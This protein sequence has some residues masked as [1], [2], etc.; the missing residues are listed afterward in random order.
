M[1]PTGSAAVSGRR[2]VNSDD[3]LRLMA[4]VARL[5]HERGMTQA[6]IASE[7][8]ISQARVSRL[9]KNATEVGIVRT[10]VTL[11]PGVHTDIEES[12][13]EK[14][15]PQGLADA[16]V[17]D[18]HGLDS[19]RALG[20]A[21]A[22]FLE[23]TLLGGDRVGISSWSATLLAM[24]EAMRP[25]RVP[26]ADRVVQLLGGMGDQRVQMQASRLLGLFASCTG[27]EPVFMPAP[28]MLG[29]PEARDSL[30]AD[31][32][33][34]TVM[35]MWPQ[36]SLALVGIG[37]LE[38]SPLLR[39]SGNALAAT[40]LKQL[41]KAGAVGDVCLRFFDAKG[42]PVDSPVNDRIV[43]I[44]HDELL[45]IPRRVG[46]AGGPNKHAAIRGALLGGWV[47]VLITD[48]EEAERLLA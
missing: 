48:L 21:A 39:E 27:A 33:V 14:Y 10:T 25:S 38:A 9:L 15:G 32:T 28:G 4:K 20:S 8:H 44:A 3:N 16:V 22:Q 23:T 6:Q 11:P 37:A 12:L 24:V 30:V 18:S 41:K 34:S 43:G 46:V 17:V 7:L 36:L 1:D 31:S 47:N 42:N 5:Y 29:S 40:D 13:I 35:T 45:K 19:T 2:L 26:T